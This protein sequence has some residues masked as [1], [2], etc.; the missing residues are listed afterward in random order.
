MLGIN[1]KSWLVEKFYEAIP[2]LL[3][4]I[5]ISGAHEDSYEAYFGLGH[6]I[7]LIDDPAV[8]KVSPAGL[9]LGNYLLRTLTNAEPVGS[10]LDLG[11]GSGVLALLLRDLGVV[12]VVATDISAEAVALARRN[13]ELNFGNSTI[14]FSTSDLF[15][16]LSSGEKFDNIIFNP[17]GWR[18][19]SATFL[20]YLMAGNSRSEIAPSAM[21]YGDKVLLRFL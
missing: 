14:R 9:A 10:Y 20:E 2:E 6:S 21:F 19:P 3:Q 12:D 7:Q 11:T 17:P 1:D 16:D 5:A 13:E 4:G 8:F 15:S 18:T